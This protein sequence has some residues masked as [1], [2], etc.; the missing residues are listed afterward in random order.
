MSARSTELFG[1][2]NM[3]GT[4]GMTWWVSATVLGATVIGALWIK[5]TDVKS[6]SRFKQ[7]ALFWLVS[8]LLFTIFAFGLFCIWASR[9]IGSNLVDACSFNESPDHCTIED[10]KLT[11]NVMT[12]GFGLGTTSFLIY[13]L[14][15]FI[16]WSE[17]PKS[18]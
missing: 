12:I 6:M 10:A 7:R 15:W 17:L 9:E 2:I 4:A 18:K 3:L 11:M 5:K 16:A 1:F 8:A 14:G 13:M